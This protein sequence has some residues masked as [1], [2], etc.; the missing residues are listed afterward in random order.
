MCVCRCARLYVSLWKGRERTRHG[1]QS[2][3]QILPTDLPPP[4]RNYCSLTLLVEQTTSIE[5]PISKDLH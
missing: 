2:P 5:Q 4:L 3:T 1:K